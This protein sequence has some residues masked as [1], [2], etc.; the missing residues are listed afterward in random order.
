M[1]V[2]RKLVSFRTR[3]LGCDTPVTAAPRARNHA[4]YSENSN[5]GECSIQTFWP[6]PCRRQSNLNSRRTRYPPSSD[7]LLS[8]SPSPTSLGSFPLDSNDRPASEWVRLWNRTPRNRA[9]NPFLR[10]FRL[11]LTW[12]LSL[13]RRFLGWPMWTWM[14]LAAMCVLRFLLFLVILRN[15]GTSSTMTT[16]T[17]SMPASMLLIPALIL[18]SYYSFNDNDFVLI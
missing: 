9:W 11:S 10:P 1:I 4:R 2:L 5:Y 12:D 17:V 6:R 3:D 13:N 15:F 16:V 14:G 7:G 18:V 8:P